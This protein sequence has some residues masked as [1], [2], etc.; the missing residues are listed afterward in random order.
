MIKS[1][2]NIFDCYLDEFKTEVI[3]KDKEKDASVKEVEIR[4]QIEGIF[5]FSAVWAMGG[6]LLQESREKFSELFRALMEK[7]FP[8]E[9]NGKFRIPPELKPQPLVKPYIFPIPKAGLVFDYRY[10]KEGKGKWRP[11][12]DELQQP[13]SIPR[14]KPVNQIIIPTM[15]TA[16]IYA[17]L[18]LLTKHSKH[19]MIIGPT[20]ML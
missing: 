4:A 19:M 11:W 7:I 8:E 6:T 5:F 20:G 13:E 3:D 15:E 1:V 16:R 9:L 18:E 10:I 17:I 14:D 12:S 2:I